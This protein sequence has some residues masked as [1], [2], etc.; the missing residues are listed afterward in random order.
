M[1]KLKSL[2]WRVVFITALSFVNVSSFLYGQDVCVIPEQKVAMVKG[3]V[4][5]L[6][7]KSVT[8]DAKVKLV[9]RIDV[10]NEIKEVATD[11]NGWFEMM[12]IP[13]GS[14]TLIVSRQNAVSLYIPIKV[15]K[16]KK[17]EQLHILLGGLIG[18]SC[19]GG[20]VK[21]INQK[22]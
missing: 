8:K 17:D 7:P 2:V 20:D 16:G 13:K 14:Y 12:D 6:N 21:K 4:S 10:S 15:G 11:E 9:S 3:F 18:E 19:G 1:K 5:F 22:P